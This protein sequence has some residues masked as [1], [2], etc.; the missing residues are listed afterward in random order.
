[1]SDLHI[2]MINN[3]S[4]PFLQHTAAQVGILLVQKETGIETVQTPEDLSTD[5][6]ETA[7]CKFNGQRIFHVRI[8]EGKLI[9]PPAENTAK[10]FEKAAQQI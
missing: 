8:G 5:Q 2:R 6:Q 1:M 4:E 9:A 10:V 7:C 3:A